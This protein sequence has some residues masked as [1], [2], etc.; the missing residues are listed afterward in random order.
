MFNINNINDSIFGKVIA[1][2]SRTELRDLASHME[3]NTGFNTNYDINKKKFNKFASAQSKQSENNKQKDF[4]GNYKYLPYLLGASILGLGVADAV[5]HGPQSALRTIG[6][7]SFEGIKRMN[8]KLIKITRSSAKAAVN[9]FNKAQKSKYSHA[10]SKVGEKIDLKNKNSIK[11]YIDMAIR[12]ESKKT[13]HDIA[14][15]VEKELKSRGIDPK[16][17]TVA[18]K[19]LQGLAYGAGLTGG[20][21]LLQAIGDEYFERKDKDELR[22]RLRETRTPFYDSGYETPKQQAERIIRNMNQGRKQQ[23]INKQASTKTDL[24]KEILR[25]D[26]LK[27]AKSSI[28]NAAVPAAVSVAINRNLKTDLSKVRRKKDNNGLGASNK[29]VVEVPLSRINKKAFEKIAAS[30]KLNSK[31]KRKALENA[32]LAIRALSWTAPPTILTALTGRNVRGLFEKNNPNV[33][34]EPL[35]PGKAR[36]IIETNKGDYNSHHNNSYQAYRAMMGKSANEVEEAVDKDLDKIRL[37][38]WLKNKARKEKSLTNVRL[39]R[40]VKKKQRILK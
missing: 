20:S 15:L 5:K 2:P 22:R 7:G 10:R 3:V 39:V 18:Q 21:L 29:I 1:N 24:L 36:I 4:L 11:N 32:R 33:N 19:A 12:D 13:R 17:Q 14:K 30:S 40:G 8:N 34:L 16:K 38:K 23:Y 35:E 28:I 9:A 37:D 25:D 26:V 27:S 31:L 6:R